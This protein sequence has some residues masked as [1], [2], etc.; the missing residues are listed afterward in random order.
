M[1]KLVVENMIDT[2][3]L[4]MSTISTSTSTSISTYNVL[5]KNSENSENTKSTDNFVMTH[6]DEYDTGDILLFSDKTFIPSLLIEYISGSKYSHVGMILK[7]P[8]YIKPDLHGLYILESTG[9][10]DICDAEDNKLKTGVQ[11]RK[12]EDV[13][14]T[15]DGAIFWRKL[16]VVRDEKFYQTITDVHTSIH[17]KPY[18][19]D[20]IDWFSGLLNVQFSDAHRTTKFFCSAM[21]TYIYHRLGLVDENT[22]WTI[23]RPKDLGTEFS[24]APTRFFKNDES[25]VKIVNCVLDNEIVIRSY[26]TYLHYIYRTM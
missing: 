1:K 23:I 18:D 12:L 21:V 6:M 19:F 13:C 25:R 8:I 20:I 11:I 22:P 14:R 4:I 16:N 9:L 3:D 15:Y 17:N 2:D 26:D 24:T 10:T 5:N 7:D